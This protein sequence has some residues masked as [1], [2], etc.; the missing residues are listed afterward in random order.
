M[1]THLAIRTE[2]DLRSYYLRRKKNGSHHL[3]AVTATAVKLCRITWRIMTD[4]RDY[5]P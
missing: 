4:E 1:M 5:I 3:A 2:S